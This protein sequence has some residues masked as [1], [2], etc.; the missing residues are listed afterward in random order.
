M[1]TKF[2]IPLMLAIVA[3]GA[4]SFAQTP[5]ARDGRVEKMGAPKTGLNAQ[6]AMFIKDAAAGNQFEIKSSELALRNGRSPFVRQFAKEM[7]ADHGAAFA[8]LKVVASKKGRM[9]SKT[10]PPAKAAI[11]KKLS[12]LHGAAFDAAYTKA[13]V[14]AHAETAAKLTKEIQNGRDGDIKGYAIKTLP[15]VKMHQKMLAM[16]KTMMGPTKMGHHM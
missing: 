13:Q 5:I 8:E 9:A 4:T 7:I 14:A 12:G 6:D 3:L 1:I 2:R 15:A 10:L 11:I 16:K